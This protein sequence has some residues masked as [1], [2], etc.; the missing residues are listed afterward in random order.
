MA[1]NGLPTASQLISSSGIF[2]RQVKQILWNKGIVT[3]IFCFSYFFVFCVVSA[4]CLVVLC[5][6]PRTMLEISVI[7]LHVILLDYRFMCFWSRN[8]SIKKKIQAL[9]TLVHHSKSHH[10]WWRE[11]VQGAY[12]QCPLWEQF[13]WDVAALD[14]EVEAGIHCSTTAMVLILGKE[15]SPFFFQIEGIFHLP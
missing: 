14:K 10:H 2:K 5:V 11:V 15:V 13:H 4:S 6:T 7:L 9:K 12:L 3:D 1:W 8:K